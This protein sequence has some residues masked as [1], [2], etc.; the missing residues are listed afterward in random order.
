M[1]RKELAARISKTSVTSN[2]TAALR[3]VD[4]I[5][6]LISEALINGEDVNLTGIGVIN[7]EVRD[8][9]NVVTFKPCKKIRDAVNKYP[10]TDLSL[11]ADLK[12]ACF[13]VVKSQPYIKCAE[14]IER[15]KREY[16]DLLAKT[17]VTESDLSKWWTGE[18]YRDTTLSWCMPFFEWSVAMPSYFEY[19]KK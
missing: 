15:V 14:W 2:P 1:N 5:L 8:G 12:K 19:T 13:D 7:T 10:V 9:Q 17:G 6:A 4:V 16:P 3:D 11:I 18:T